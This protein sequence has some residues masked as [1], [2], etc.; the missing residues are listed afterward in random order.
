MEF[1]RL[2]ELAADLHCFSPGM[3]TAGEDIDQVRVQLN[4][5]VKSGRVIRLHKGWYTL[6]EP[7]RH[8]RIDVNVIASTIK[9]GTYVSLQSALAFHGMIPEY[10][11]ETTCVI[12]GRPLTIGTPFGRIRYRHIKGEVFFGYSRYEVGMQHAFIAVPEKALLDLLYLT[13]GS[14]DADYL[15][16]LRLHGVEDFDIQLMLQM[17]RKFQAKRLERSVDLVSRLTERGSDPL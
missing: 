14:E 13:P 6:G 11:P 1:S 7:Y 5:W 10:V 12:T 3:I 2:V 4:R 16:E 9:P 17:A 15:S 8:V